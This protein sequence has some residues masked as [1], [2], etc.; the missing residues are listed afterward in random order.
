M[1][2]VKLAKQIS[3]YQKPVP[4]KTRSIPALKEK[5]LAMRTMVTRESVSSMTRRMNIPKLQRHQIE[6]KNT[7]KSLT[8]NVLTINLLS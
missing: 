6:L 2:T 8:K 1:V 5:F 7:K 4:L 3:N